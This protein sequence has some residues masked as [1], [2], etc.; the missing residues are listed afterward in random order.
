MTT[1]APS[2]KL[3]LFHSRLAGNEDNY[4]ISNEFDIRPD[5]TKDFGVSCP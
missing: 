4:K 5:L 2:F 1:L 3:D